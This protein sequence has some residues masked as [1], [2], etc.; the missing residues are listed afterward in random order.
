MLPIPTPLAD[1]CVTI[2][3]D[4]RV[5]ADR[6]SDVAEKVAEKDGPLRD[7]VVA[8]RETRSSEDTRLCEVGFVL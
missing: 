1:C 5:A 7:A 3:R 6:L 2:P 4:A 8:G